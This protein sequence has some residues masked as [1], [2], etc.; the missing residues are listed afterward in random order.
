MASYQRVGGEEARERRRLQT[1][2][3]QRRY[4]EKKK[5]GSGSRNKTEIA[6]CSVDEA[7]SIVTTYLSFLNSS[8]DPATME[9]KDSGNHT[10]PYTQGSS[11]MTEEE[12]SEAMDG[13]APQFLLPM[14]SSSSFNK[15]SY[16][17]TASS[18]SSSSLIDSQCRISLALKSAAEREGWIGI[19]LKEYN[20]ATLVHF[21]SG[22]LSGQINIQ[23]L[24]QGQTIFLPK[25]DFCR[26][27]FANALALSFLASDLNKCRDISRIRDVWTNT[28]SHFDNIPDNMIPV[29]EQLEV[30]H[31]IILDILPWPSVRRKALKAIQA[32]ILEMDIF[33]RDA[34]FGCDEEFG[35]QSAF[36]IH[37]VS[38]DDDFF[39]NSNG[40]SDITMDPA[41]WQCSQSWLAKYWFLV[42][43]K[44][45]RRTN[46]WRRMQ[47]LSSISVPVLSDLSLSSI[48]LLEL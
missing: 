9:D 46:W 40:A 22:N 30:N 45:V 10:N 36:Q 11:T 34:F 1:R 35:Y 48:G 16:P 17:P 13:F 23:M 20:V 26:A 39:F 42:D 18:S 27:F 14:S 44:I 2:L 37:G 8:L 31:N 15:A 43:A 3:A 6:A 29:Q 32:G 24:R 12:I 28:R 33:K 25:L 38:A 4:R 5:G 47:G 19:A 21:L 41:S 7:S